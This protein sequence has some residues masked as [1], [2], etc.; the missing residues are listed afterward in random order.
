MNWCDNIC[1]KLRRNR[2]N[3]TKLMDIISFEPYMVFLFLFLLL[4]HY[5]PVSQM[6]ALLV[7]C[8]EIA[9]DYN[10]LLKVLYVFEH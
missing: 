2:E 8:L 5:R 7:A 6:R 3:I 1:F 9:G 4:L 10:R